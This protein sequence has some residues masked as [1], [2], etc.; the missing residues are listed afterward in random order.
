MEHFLSENETTCYILG[1]ITFFYITFFNLNF[2]LSPF[3]TLS[4]SYFQALLHFFFISFWVSCYI[5][6]SY[7]LHLFVFD[8]QSCDV[9]EMS[10]LFLGLVLN[11]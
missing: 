1:V 8:M 9:T 2:R 11:L 3:V 10:R 4:I 7:Y 5:S 6:A